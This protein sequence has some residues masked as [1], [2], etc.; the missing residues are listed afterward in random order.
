MA[1]RVP[2]GQEGGGDRLDWPGR[3]EW[4]LSGGGMAGTALQMREQRE[5]QGW[6]E[7]DAL[8]SR[9]WEWRR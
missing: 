4:S 8:S 2:T 3:P 5:G 1:V 7:N 9:G 6:E